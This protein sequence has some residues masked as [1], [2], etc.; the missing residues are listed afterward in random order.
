MRVYVCVSVCGHACYGDSDDAG[1]DGNGDNDDGD[2]D[3]D[4]NDDHD[5]DVAWYVGN[6]DCFLQAGLPIPVQKG[7]R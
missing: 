6:G 2:D 1:A 5:D 7:S 3:G 4:D